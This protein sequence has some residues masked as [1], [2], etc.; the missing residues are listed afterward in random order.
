MSELSQVENSGNQASTINR[1]I[2]SNKFNESLVDIGNYNLSK[3]K[4]Q[5]LFKNTLR[6]DGSVILR[7]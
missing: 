2:K 3:D 7:F 5:H 1:T 4:C 6:G